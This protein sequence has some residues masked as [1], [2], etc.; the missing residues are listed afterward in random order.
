M[1]RL[2]LYDLR[3][4]SLP[5]KIGRCAADGPQIARAVNEAQLRLLYAKEAGD[6]GWYG[7]WAEMAFNVSRENPYITT[8]RGVAR[9]ELMTVCNEPVSIQNQIY[10]YLDFGNGTLPKRCP[11]RWRGSL[12]AYSR[13]NVPTFTDLS[14]APQLIRA[15]FSALDV[16]RRALVQG[17]D[18]N[19][20]TIYSQDGFQRV[21]GQFMTFG[22][23]P[24]TS[25]VTWPQQFNSITGVQKD[26]TSDPVSFYQVDPSTGVETLLLIME[27]GETTAWY[28]RY[29]LGP[30]PRNCAPQTSET[31][32][33]VRAIVKLDLVPVVVDTD[34]CLI[35]N[36]EA[37][38]AEC[39]AGRY[40]EVDTSDAKQQARERHQAAIGLLI[41]ELGHYL[42][43]DT[44][45]VQ[46]LP[47]GSA[48]LERVAIS[49]Q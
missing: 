1:Q 15:Y 42:G 17:L 27:P 31:T 48:R 10:E 12:Q 29:Y 46:V 18:S 49:M 33:Q 41:G 14:S 4:G 47:F 23:V 26:I 19:G 3:T 25:F 45:A 16:S 40:A 6:E 5:G 24:N 7:T 34:Y 37:L 36:P 28:R 20:N 11:D 30:L 44:P 22:L 21:S 38:N 9:L 13:N 43:I 39:Q 2:R 32:A 35:Q 8:P